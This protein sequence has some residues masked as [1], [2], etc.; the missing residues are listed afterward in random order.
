MFKT[1]GAVPEEM[2]EKVPGV[3]F[4]GPGRFSAAVASCMVG[5]P[6][7]VWGRSQESFRH[8]FSADNPQAVQTTDLTW[9]LQQFPYWILGCPVQSVRGVL[10]SIDLSSIPAPAWVLSLGKGIEVGTGL[11]VRQIIAE[12]FPEARTGV[13]AGPNL[14]AEV[15]AGHPCGMVVASECKKMAAQVKELLQKRPLLDLQESAFPDEVE[16]YGALKNVMAFGFGLLMQSKLDPLSF[17][18]PEFCNAKPDNPRAGDPGSY[19][20]AP[21]HFGPSENAKALFMTKAFGEMRGFMQQILQKP[22]DEQT[23]LGYG[24]LGDFILTCY[25]ASSRNRQAG[26]QFPKPLQ[27]LCEGQY[28]LQAL[29]GSRL[30]EGLTGILNHLVQVCF[31]AYDPRYLTKSS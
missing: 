5:V 28:T 24:G 10:A 15:L 4:L 29:R 27:E 7:A 21:H 20:Q 8:D 25:A 2:T 3:V 11:R 9:A 22:L 12:F 18:N 23:S 19:N 14:A 1:T 16:W 26:Q 13:L 6:V 17:D 30:G 31:K